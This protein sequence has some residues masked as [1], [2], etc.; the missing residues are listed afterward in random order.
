[1]RDGG[2]ASK[3]ILAAFDKEIP[4]LPRVKRQTPSEYW[5]EV[6]SVL[7]AEKQMEEIRKLARSRETASLA[8]SLD[9]LRKQDLNYKARG[10]DA[11]DR[12]VLA[13]GIAD[14]ERASYLHKR[15]KE[16]GD[17]NTFVQNAIRRNLITK[18]VMQQMNILRNNEGY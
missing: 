16:S 5:S 13:L 17:Y 11:K 14:G 9:N 10:I 1:M 3:D 18:D 2:I 4:D 12:L 8:Q 6:I 7:P 15:A